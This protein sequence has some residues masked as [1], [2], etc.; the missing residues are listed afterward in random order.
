MGRTDCGSEGGNVGPTEGDGT[1]GGNEGP[2]DFG[3]AD[4]GSSGPETF[5]RLGLSWFAP[6]EVEESF[7]CAS[8]C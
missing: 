3:E 1:V 8:S 6:E 5:W 4:G 7:F 2:A